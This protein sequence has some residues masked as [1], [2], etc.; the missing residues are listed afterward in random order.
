MKKEKPFALNK[1]GGRLPAFKMPTP[2]YLACPPPRWQPKGLSPDAPPLLPACVPGSKM[3]AGRERKPCLA[4]LAPRGSPWL[5]AAGAN[6]RRG[7]A[8][9]PAPAASADGWQCLLTGAASAAG[10]GV[11]LGGGGVRH[12][13]QARGGGGAGRGPGGAAGRGERSRAA[14]GDPPPR[15]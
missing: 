8:R 2:S 5:P 15:A 10:L 7:G 11:G 12:P 1:D 4:G 13:A 9:G 14:A 3:A 6:G